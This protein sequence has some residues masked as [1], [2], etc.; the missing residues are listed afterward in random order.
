MV[1]DRTKMESKIVNMTRISLKKYVS[2]KGLS[3]HNL[4]L[5]KGGGGQKD[6]IYTMS[7]NKTLFNTKKY[8]SEIA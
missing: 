4:S 8:I 2:G 7:M 3:R 5:E 6:Y 1:T